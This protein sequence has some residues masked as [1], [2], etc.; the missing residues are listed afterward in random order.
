MAEVK[1]IKKGTNPEAYE[2][3]YKKAVAKLKEE[4]DDAKLNY[5]RFFDISFVKF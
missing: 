5:S 4:N 3:Y 2:K 1:E